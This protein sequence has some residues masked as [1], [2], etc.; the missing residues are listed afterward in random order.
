MLTI[1]IERNAKFKVEARENEDVMPSRIKFTDPVNFTLESQLK[2]RSPEQ[3]KGYWSRLSQRHYQ[4][5]CSMSLKKKKTTHSQPPTESEIA[6]KSVYYKQAQ[7][8]LRNLLL[9][10]SEEP[11]LC[12]WAYQQ[13]H[14]L[15]GTLS[16]EVTLFRGQDSTNPLLRAGTMSSVGWPATGVNK[17]CG[18]SCIP[19]GVWSLGLSDS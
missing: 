16:I 9:S 8:Q 3:S 7:N 19:K 4:V 13:A 12:P 5:S 15:K 1:V 11:G 17:V 6:H 18:L 10:P 2:S 14:W